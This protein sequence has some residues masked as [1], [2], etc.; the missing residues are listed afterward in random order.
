MIEQPRLQIGWQTVP[1]DRYLGQGQFQ[2][3]VGSGLDV[4]RHDVRVTLEDGREATLPGV[5]EVKPYLNFWVEPIGA[6]VQD[7]P[8]T[9]TLRATTGQDAEPYG[10]SVKLTLYKA[11]LPIPVT[12]DRCGPFSGGMCRIQ[13][14]LD[15]PDSHY[16]L[17]LAD[18]Q[19]R[20]AN[21]NSFRVDPKN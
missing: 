13:L 17:A 7:Q 18:D 10:G 12:P 11:G 21:S 14:T 16:I 8:F 19:G 2:G 3:T 9:V 1:L 4:G 15:S 20:S 5:Y 6:Q